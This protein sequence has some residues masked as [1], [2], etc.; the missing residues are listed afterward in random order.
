MKTE[1]K[2]KLPP[3]CFKYAEGTCSKSSL[4]MK[5]MICTSWLQLIFTCHFYLRWFSHTLFLFFNAVFSFLSPPSTVVVLKQM[6]GII[7]V[8]TSCI[9]PQ[10]LKTPTQMYFLSMIHIVRRLKYYSHGICAVFSFSLFLPYFSNNKKKK[11][12]KISKYIPRIYKISHKP[13]SH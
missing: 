3:F 13:W 8:Y 6:C 1:Q 12:K 10:Q 7:N 5:V 4:L 2:R 11:F 9:V